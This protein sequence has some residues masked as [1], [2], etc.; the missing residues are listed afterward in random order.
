[1]LWDPS[2]L[3]PI[4]YEE[5]LETKMPLFKL[6]KASNNTNRDCLCYNSLLTKADMSQDKCIN[7]EYKKAK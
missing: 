4:Q 6:K 2:L 5:K 3:Q 7:I 1:M